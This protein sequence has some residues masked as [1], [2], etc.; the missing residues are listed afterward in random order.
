MKEGT[1]AQIL[2]ITG[3]RVRVL[4]QDG[5]VVRSRRGF[6]DTRASIKNYCA[7]LREGASRAGKQPSE[8]SDQKAEVLRLTRAKAD[9]EEARVA[10]ERGELIPIDDVRR[11]WTDLAVNL[12]SQILNIGPR[13][14][15]RTGLDRDT[16]AL[17]E[18]ELRLALTELDNAR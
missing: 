10:R 1:L 6:Y 4:A 7:R 11:E 18:E 2:G 16:A 15:A 12:R 13:V 8:S 3:N 17:L 9:R 14:S 5:V